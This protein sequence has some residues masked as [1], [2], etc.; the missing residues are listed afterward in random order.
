VAYNA[1]VSPNEHLL[2]NPHIT[3]MITKF[4]TAINIYIIIVSALSVVRYV[5]SFGPD[6]SYNIL[7]FS[8]DR[9]NVKPLKNNLYTL[10]LFKN[11]V[12]AKAVM[13]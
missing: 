7:A 1:L 10:H 11:I 12:Y 4:I 13:Y 9:R 2:I 6:L 5:V 3:D 8:L